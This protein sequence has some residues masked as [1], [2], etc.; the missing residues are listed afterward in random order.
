MLG[1]GNIGQFLLESINGKEKLQE[2]KIVSIYSRNKE[3][4]NK[5]AVQYGATSYE[6]IESFLNSNIDL[7]VEVAT[8]EVV[9]EVAVDILNKKIDLLVSSIGVFGNKPFFNKVIDI[10]NRNDVN[11]YIPSGAVGGLDILK[12]AK[13]MGGLKKVQVITRKPPI[14]LT[15]DDI[16]ETEKEIF[17]GNAAEAITL[18]PRNMNIGI[19]VS[20]AGIG[21]EQTKVKVISDPTIDKNRHTIYAEGLFGEFKIEIKNEAMPNNPKTSYLAAL[22]VLSSIQHKNDKLKIG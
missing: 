21:P 20:L 22:S 10:C 11:V 16:D 13:T 4:T 15:T 19:A 18:F 3:K 7:V 14:A 17:S 1:C 8:I 5:I 12:S 9:K 2:S 6:S